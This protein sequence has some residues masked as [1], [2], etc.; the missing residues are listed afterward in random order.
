MYK[1]N[2][3]KREVLVFRQF[4][5]KGYSLFACLGREVVISVLSVAT[6]SATKAAGISDET[7]RVDSTGATPT[8]WLADVGVVGSR[9]PLAQSQAARMVSVLSR[10]DIAKAPVQSVNDLLKYAVGVDVRQRGAFGTQS[11]ISIRGGTS[12]QITIMLNGINIGDPQTSHNA[13]DLPIQLSEIVRIEILEGPAGRAYGTSSLVGAI[14]IVTRPSSDTSADI[15]VEGGSYGYAKASLRFS[16]HTTEHPSPWSHQLSGSYQRSDGFSRAADGTLNTDH[17][18]T[19]AFY[20]GQYVTPQ[21]KVSWSAGISDKGWGSSTF[22]ATPR[23]TSDDQYE[24]TTKLFTAL[25]AEAAAGSLHFL[26]S[27]YWQQHY[28]R[29]EGHRGRPD[30]MKFNYNRCD[31]YGLCLNSYVDWIAG[32]TTLGAEVRNE[33]LMSGNLGEALFTPRHIHGTDRDYT[34][35][36]NRTNI[37]AHLEH[38]V[39]LKRLTL[40]AGFVAAKSSWSD[41]QLKLYPGAD[42]SYRL[43]DAVTLYASYNT[44]LRLPSFTEMYYKLQGYAADPHLKPEEM[45][46]V[47]LGGQYVW[48]ERGLSPKMSAKAT[49]YHHHGSNMID[50]IMDTTQG[51]QTKWQSVNHTEINTYGAEANA[52]FDITELLWPN[53]SSRP[54]STISLS[55][56]YISQDKKEDKNIVSQYALEYLRHKL[57]AG[58]HWHLWRQL[59]LDLTLRWNDR[60]GTY[61]TFDGISH[62]YRPFALIDGK[63][64]WKG[65]K[66]KVYAEVNNLLD[67][68]SYVDYGNVPQPGTWVVTGME[69]HF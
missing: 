18:G 52:M 15:S 59:S 54:H 43:T 5:R 33:D 1:P 32:R 2:F 55:Y 20:Q 66:Y 38:N 14:N 7:W 44:S 63:L 53:N 57:V 23:W 6:L 30:L 67:N 35:G 39:L 4:Q 10:E 3:Q 69:W 21:A 62:S 64:T 27:L 24:H 17:R 28:D 41:M 45:Q 56:S 65:T 12:E 68:T 42:V 11:D 48:A 37:A 61:T 9:A 47:E 31:V 46:A 26:P 16:L 58:S 49:V 29:Y 25:Q 60:V 19:K 40:S 36:I 34:L 13:V 51:T 8:V 22:Y 50:W